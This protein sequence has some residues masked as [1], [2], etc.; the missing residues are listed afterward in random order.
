MFAVVH[1]IDLKRKKTMDNENILEDLKVQYPSEF[2]GWDGFEITWKL[3]KRRDR[4]DMLV[5]LL[6]EGT[7]GYAVDLHACF[8]II[9]AEDGGDIIRVGKHGLVTEFNSIYIPEFA[10]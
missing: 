9:Q 4:I 6:N 7:D 1:F 3:R 2:E 5:T 10:K 8:L